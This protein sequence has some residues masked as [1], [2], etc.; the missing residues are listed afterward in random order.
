MIRSEIAASNG[1]VL[2]SSTTTLKFR[3]ALRGGIPSS[4]TKT[5]TTFVDGP[6]SSIGVQAINPFVGLIDIPPGALV[7][8]LKVSTF[9]GMSGS[10]AELV[11]SR[12]SPS[13]T[14]WS[15]I[16]NNT[17]GLFTSITTTMN[18][19]RAIMTGDPSSATIT[20]TN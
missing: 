13:T 12:V 10:V 6:C 14:T 7:P 9:A 15:A 1:G 16:G 19:W 5:L 2:V 20:V 11:T 8:R 3:M 18:F 17:G 4:V